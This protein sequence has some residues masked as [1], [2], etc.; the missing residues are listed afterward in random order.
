MRAWDGQRDV[1]NGGPGIDSATIDRFD[2][3][4]SIERK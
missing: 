3:T 4:I 2:R 1:L